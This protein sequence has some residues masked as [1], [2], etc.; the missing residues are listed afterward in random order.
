LVVV[1]AF[2]VVAD[3]AKQC[4]TMP[5]TGNRMSTLRRCGNHKDRAVTG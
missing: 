1:P 2:Y 5:G 4:F 3:R